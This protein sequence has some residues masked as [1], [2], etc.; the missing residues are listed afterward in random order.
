[1]K[2]VYDLGSYNMLDNIRHIEMDKLFT[3]RIDTLISF[4]N[5]SLRLRL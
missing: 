5:T 1:M 2:L 4:S 3:D